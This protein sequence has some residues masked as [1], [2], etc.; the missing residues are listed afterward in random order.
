MTSEF[1]GKLHEKTDIAIRAI[2]VFECKLSWNS[3]VMQRIFLEWHKSTEKHFSN[4]CMLE[5]SKFFQFNR[6]MAYRNQL[7]SAQMETQAVHT[8]L[9]IGKP[10]P[11]DADKTWKIPLELQTM[12]FKELN[13]FKDLSE[14]RT[15]LEYC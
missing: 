2:S 1:H 4:V 7:F 6:F 14:I 11:T 3:L 9:L 8:E 15:E 12:W 10:R 13:F 5:D